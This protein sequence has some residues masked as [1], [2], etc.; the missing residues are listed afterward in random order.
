MK[1]KYSMNK[2]SGK[3]LESMCRL[4]FYFLLGHIMKN[5]LIVKLY[6]CIVHRRTAEARRSCK[7]CL[8]VISQKSTPRADDG[9]RITPELARSINPLEPLGPT[10]D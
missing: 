4:Q 1:W 2:L 9:P 5:T 10:E 8:N 7:L 3:Q 6:D